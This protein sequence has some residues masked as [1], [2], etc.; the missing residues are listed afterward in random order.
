[1]VYYQLSIIIE[2]IIFLL[3]PTCC[4]SNVLHA[5]RRGTVFWSEANVTRGSSEHVMQ[6]EPPSML[7]TRH[8]VSVTH[9]RC[10]I[11]A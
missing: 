10:L 3:I 8:E 11:L 7:V 6:T 1:M 9:G 2:H 5:D 4:V